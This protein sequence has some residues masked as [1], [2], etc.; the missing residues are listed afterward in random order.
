MKRE[1]TCI[2]CPKGCQMT[3]DNIDGQYVVDGNSCIR[4]SRYGVDEVTNPKRMITTT[5]RLEGSY[6]NMLPVKTSSS[7]PKDM[8]FDI[9]HILSTIKITAPVNVGDII[10]ENILDTGVDIVSCKTMNNIDLACE[11]EKLR[12]IL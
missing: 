4:G 11:K 2:V 8:V 3:V 12:K 6:L 5:V 1:I 9:M 10:V 7:V